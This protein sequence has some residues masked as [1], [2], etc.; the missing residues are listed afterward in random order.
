MAIREGLRVGTVRRR[1]RGVR[2]QDYARRD[3]FDVWLPD[4]APSSQ[5]V[6]WVMSEPW[7]PKRWA[8]F[9]RR[10]RREMRQPTAER[11]IALL[12]AL[13][14]QTDFSVGCYCD[15]EARCHRTFL[16]E[17]LVERGAKMARSRSA[18]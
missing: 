12:A 18:I 15:D 9:A 13:S 10:F 17:L 7:T 8:T 14:E 4:L 2:K 16:R 5:L 3:F 6:S 11:L 1:P